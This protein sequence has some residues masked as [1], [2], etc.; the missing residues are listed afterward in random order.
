MG[1]SRSGW[2]RRLDDLAFEVERG[3]V[4]AFLAAMTVMVF[5]DVLYRRLVD[6]ETKLGGWIARHLEIADAD[7]AGRKRKREPLRVDVAEEYRDRVLGLA[8][9]APR[10]AAQRRP[11]QILACAQPCRVEIL[12]PDRPCALKC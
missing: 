9:F 12:A 8:Y 7:Q 11:V 6:Q 2:L 3:L 5:L 10:G 1:E 4:S